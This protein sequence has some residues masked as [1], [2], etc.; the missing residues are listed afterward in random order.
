WGLD[1]ISIN[2]EGIDMAAANLITPEIALKYK[3]L[4]VRIQDGKLLVAMSNP[5]DIIAIDDIELI[6]GYEV[7]PIIVVDREL[8]IAL[9]RFS[10]ISKNIDAQDEFEQEAEEKIDSI[11]DDE[12]NEKPAVQL[13]NQVL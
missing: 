6:T 9:E 4:P 2:K 3:L 7:Q 5:N 1:F 13:V 12:V 10:N 8:N 11:D